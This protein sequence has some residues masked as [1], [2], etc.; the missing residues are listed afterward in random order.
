MCFVQVENKGVFFYNV[1]TVVAVVVVAL[2]G[3]GVGISGAHSK[4]RFV[5]A[6]ART[7]A[8]VASD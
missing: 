1:V 3:A 7:C 2:G 5:D 4:C 8:S 6:C